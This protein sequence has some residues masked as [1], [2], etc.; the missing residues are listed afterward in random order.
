MMPGEP[1]MAQS[2]S[3]GAEIIMGHSRNDATPKGPTKA[4]AQGADPPP[5]SLEFHPK[6]LPPLPP[7]T[8]PK[9]SKRAR[10]HRLDL[11]RD[12]YVSRSEVELDLQSRASAF[13]GAD[14]NQDGKLDAEELRQYQKQFK[15]R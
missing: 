12:G 6:A 8:Y 11:D 5:V 1:T 4:K 2:T 15:P 9:K 3:P 13:R 7:Q 14:H 10:K